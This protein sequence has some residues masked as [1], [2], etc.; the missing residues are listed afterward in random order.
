MNFF[1]KPKQ[2]TAIVFFTQTII[3]LL[4]MKHFLYLGV[5]SLSFIPFFVGFPFAFYYIYKFILND[6][7][8]K[9]E[10]AERIPYH[11]NGYRQPTLDKEE[12]DKE[13]FEPSKNEENEFLEVNAILEPALSDDA[14]PLH[15]HGF[16]E[17]E[18]IE[19]IMEP[20]EEAEPLPSAKRT[21]RVEARKQIQVMNINDVFEDEEPAPEEIAVVPDIKPVVVKKAKPH[22]QKRKQQAS[23]EA[24]NL[25]LEHKTVEVL[26]KENDSIA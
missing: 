4:N 11:L 14:E 9:S 8:S 13:A 20:K 21:S 3:A 1:D 24:M 18:I 6:L 10:E 17:V 2:V 16:V 19:P 26:T 22:R 7:D 25:A 12:H 5:F 23:K 15:I